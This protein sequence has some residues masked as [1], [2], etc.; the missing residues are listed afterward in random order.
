MIDVPDSI[1]DAFIIVIVRITTDPIPV[2]SFLEIVG[3]LL[4]RGMIPLM[5][6]LAMSAGVDRCL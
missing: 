6:M 2:E 3:C 4:V 1:L 5:S